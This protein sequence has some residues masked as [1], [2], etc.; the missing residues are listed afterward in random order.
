MTDGELYI[1]EGVTYVRLMTVRLL[2]ELDGRLMGRLDIR[3]PEDR[4]PARPPLLAAIT[5]LLFPKN[6][7]SMAWAGATAAIFP[8]MNVA[9]STDAATFLLVSSLLD[10]WRDVTEVFGVVAGAKADAPETHSRAITAVE[11]LNIIF[12]LLLL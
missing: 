10:I 11:N 2:L 5:V 7:S 3:A 12:K 8:K 6:E 1:G 4:P 9:A